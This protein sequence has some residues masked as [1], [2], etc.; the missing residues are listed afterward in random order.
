MEGKDHGSCAGDRG[1][2]K[3][4]HTRPNPFREQKKRR[5]HSPASSNSTKYIPSP[6]TCSHIFCVSKFCSTKHGEAGRTCEVHSRHVEIAKKERD[7]SKWVDTAFG[8]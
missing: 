2:L 4:D 7:C 3:V 5:P 1:K 8:T 6:L